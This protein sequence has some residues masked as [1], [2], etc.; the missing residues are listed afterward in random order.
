[1]EKYYYAKSVCITISLE[2]ND[3]HDRQLITAITTMREGFSKE[4]PH[5]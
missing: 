4:S 1:M 5:L 2:W 3:R